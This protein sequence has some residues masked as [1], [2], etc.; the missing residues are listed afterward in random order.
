VARTVSALLLCLATP[1]ASAATLPFSIPT[2]DGATSLT[3]EV[4]LPIGLSK[5]AE[6]GTQVPAVVMVPG[7]GQFDRDV[8]FGTSG[9]D[10]DLLFKQLAEALTAHGIAVVRQDYRGVHCNG[11]S[12]KKKSENVFDACIEKK[13]RKNVS[14]EQMRSDFFQVYDHA[15]NLPCIE[16]SQITVFGHSEASFHVAHLVQQKKISPRALVFMGMVA[17]SPKSLVHWQAVERTVGKLM[18][19]NGSQDRQALTEKYEKEYADTV[20]R[21][22]AQPDEKVHADFWSYKWWKMWWSD[23]TRV[24]D[25]LKDY[26]GEI[27]AHLADED[28]SVSGPRQQEILR[29]ET[30]K[31]KIPPKIVMHSGKG[32]SLGS[33]GLRGPISPDSFK[34]V[35]DDIVRVSGVDIEKLPNLTEEETAA[36][37]YVGVLFEISEPLPRDSR[38]KSDFGLKLLAVTPGLPG[39]D[40]GLRAGDI[41]L[42]MNGEEIGATQKENALIH[43]IK[44]IQALT[45]GD[46]ATLSVLRFKPELEARKDGQPIE[47]S[48]LGGQVERIGDSAELGKEYEL[49]WRR[50]FEVLEK[51][52]EVKLPRKMDSNLHPSWDKAPPE[53][54]EKLALKTVRRYGTEKEFERVKE[55][56]REVTPRPDPF[57]LAE[58]DYL[59][60]HPFMIKR[61][62]DAVIRTSVPNARLP[63]EGMLVEARTLLAPRAAKLPKLS[64]LK[65]GLTPQQHLEAIGAL[66]EEVNRLWSEAYK[67][68]KPEEL[69][70]LRGHLDGLIHKFEEWNYVY[71]DTDPVRLEHNYQVIHLAAKADLEPLIRGARRLA[72]L[73]EPDY[74]QGL[75]ADLARAGLD[76]KLPEVLKQKTPYGEILV[77]GSGNDWH[78]DIEERGFAVLIDLGGDDVYGDRSGSSTEKVHA[79][80]VVDLEG[81][82][83]Y[84]SRLD[85]AIGSGLMGIGIVADLAGDDSYL[86]MRASEGAGVLG[87]GLLIDRAGNDHYR[88]NSISQG[89]SFMGVSGLT[90]LA[91]NDR[92]DS[93]LLSQAVAIAGGFAGLFDLEGNDSYFS[94]GL[95]GSGYGTPG[96]FEGW[97][98]G[99]GVGIRSLVSGGVAILHDGGGD[100][101]MRGGDFSQGGGYY[102]GWGIL[103]K[104][105]SGN[106]E[107]VGDRY[108]QGFAAHYA[109]GTFIDEGGADHYDSRSGVTTGNANDL[110]VSWFED[111]GGDDQYAAKNFSLGA[112]ANNSISVFVDHGGKDRYVGDALPASGSSNEYRG[113]TSAAFSLDLGGSRASGPKPAPA[114]QVTDQ[115]SF[116][117]SRK[118]TITGLL[119]GKWLESVLKPRAAAK[120]TSK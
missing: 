16:R 87:V 72:Q 6:K 43:F 88:A 104:G 7:T 110:S 64:P 85:Y 117:F 68:L 67:N 75:R 91:G 27:V 82:D 31:F 100:D 83:S 114:C 55:N 74:V 47:V 92:Y 5:C 90:D 97:S 40:A 14:P 94:R 98:Q 99:V 21:E 113:G 57:R 24:V 95:T 71:K 23:E 63:V 120:R 3:G 79:S 13:V 12:M 50:G 37:P 66:L 78:G 18:R 59:Q 22:M 112:A 34:L 46:Q 8:D 56:I 105:G 102:Y 26:P 118:S 19:E 69:T 62:S 93:R 15:A 58:I 54:L 42:G 20:A 45:P 29:A 9:T 108:A 2:E 30:P 101:H 4:D 76:L 35:V 39:W 80:I 81:K 10:K 84:E 103:H 116:V 32:H 111:L 51:K 109:L 107:Y 49:K 53:P 106:D 1:R 41:L 89:C 28:T 60:H 115:Y 17:E 86:G 96:T 25:Q 38:F 48:S 44:R 11:H 33:D 70:Y 61:A 77:A 73:S 119:E 65:T 36:R 52:F